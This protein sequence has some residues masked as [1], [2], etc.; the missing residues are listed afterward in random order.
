METIQR[1]I[2]SE[3]IMSGHQRFAINWLRFMI[4]ATEAIVSH[5]QELSGERQEKNPNILSQI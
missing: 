4:D 5:N 3:T 1:Y 2:K